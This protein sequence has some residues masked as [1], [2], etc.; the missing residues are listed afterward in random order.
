M[1]AQGL[2]LGMWLILLPVALR[3]L[4]QHEIGLWLVFLTIA[5]L[6]QLLE[7]GFQPTIARNVAYVY[8][9]AQNLQPAGLLTAASGAVNGQLV[10]NL[11]AASQRIYTVMA[12]AA[13]GLLWIVGTAY[14]VSIAPSDPSLSTSLFAWLAFSA[15][16]VINFYYGYLNAFLQGR[17]DMLLSNKVLV[18]SR[19]VQLFLSAGLIA[20]GARL[21]GL[22]IASLVSTVV[23]RFMAYRY[24]R[25]S[26]LPTVS[27]QTASAQQVNDLVKILWHNASRHG[28]V[29]VGAFLITRANILIASSRLGLVEATGFALSI[30]ILLIL[31]ALAMLPFNL[32]LPRLNLMR[33]QGRTDAMQ[34]IFGT[35]LAAALGLF[36]LA[37]MSLVILGKPLLAYIGSAT[38]LPGPMVLSA[39]S[40]VFLLE[41]NH[42]ICGNFITTDNQVPFMK[43]ALFTGLAITTT[44]WWIA[45]S[46]GVVGF[47]MTIG[48]WQVIYNNWKWPMEAARLL[49]ASYWRVLGEGFMGLRRRRHI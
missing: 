28:A 22:G 49:G 13:A 31:Q 11:F 18:T 32:A 39:F 46:F 33:A 45:P 16:Y 14:V 23:G 17:G 40:V 24:L 27:G 12:A 34:R 8:A 25:Q 3:Y 48:F 10:A 7:L 4:P 6:A 42:G 2:S 5:S 36:V 20:C 44:A 41:L 19:I 37:A 35:A 43:A 1:A 30:Q 29:M 26:S 47:L 38:T 21:L 15:G 9:G